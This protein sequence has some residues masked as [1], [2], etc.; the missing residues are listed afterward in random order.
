MITRKPLWQD[1]SSGDGSIRFNDGSPSSLRLRHR[2]GSGVK[3]CPACHAETVAG[4]QLVLASVGF[5]TACRACRRG[6]RVS[7]GWQIALALTWVTAAGLGVG[8]A[9]MYQQGF[10]QTLAPNGVLVALLLGV[11]PMLAACFARPR[12]KPIRTWFQV[13]LPWIGALI[14]LA[15]VVAVASRFWTQHG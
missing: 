9:A 14:G 12:V 8:V 15:M 4:W 6:L 7:R 3:A 5:P 11:V 2:A 1:R 10:T 13:L